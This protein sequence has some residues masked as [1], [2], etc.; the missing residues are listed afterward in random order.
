MLAGLGH[1]CLLTPLRRLVEQ[2]RHIHTGGGGG[3]VERNNSV[4]ENE[5]GAENTI[6]ATTGLPTTM[7]TSTTTTTTDGRSIRHMNE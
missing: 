7:T 5:F 4:Q 3:R 2:A 1:V 6:G